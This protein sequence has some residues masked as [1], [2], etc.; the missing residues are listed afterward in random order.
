MEK[1]NRSI[2]Y[3]IALTGVFGALSV[4]LSFT[5]LGY[6]QIGLL[7]ITI[8]HIPVILAVILAGL[9]PGVSVGLIF[10]LSSL[11]RAA[12][13]GSPFFINPFCSVLPR[14]LFPV[15]VWAI[16]KLL[17]KLPGFSKVISGSIAAA[18]GTLCHTLIVMA[19]LYIF[20]AEPL[21]QGMK[22]AMEQFGFSTD[23]LSPVGGFIAIIACTLATNGIWEII[24]ATIIV[25]TVLTSIYAVKN[26]KSKLSKIEELQ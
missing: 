18:V 26:K 5:P 3:K 13:T 2:N 1:T 7:A 24:T 4:V 11:I 17:N 16:C 23:N 22:G 19:A 21:L 10:G 15:A 9:V 20:Y 25:A 12:Q 14:M 8:M 6:I